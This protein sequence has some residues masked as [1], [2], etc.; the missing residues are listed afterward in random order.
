MESFTLKPKLSLIL[1]VYN[2]MPW[3]NLVLS[4]AIAQRVSVPYEIIVCDDGSSDRFFDEVRRMCAESRPDL[5]YIWQPDEGF[6]LSR[7]RNNAIRCAQGELLVFADGDTWLAP[8]FLQEHLDAHAATAAL[9]C[10]L[11]AT[12]VA[13]DIKGDMLDLRMIGDLFADLRS[14]NQP[15]IE[16]QRAWFNSRRPWMAC[17]G[18]NFSI[19]SQPQY[20]FDEVFEGWG[21]EDRDFAYRMF[22]AGFKPTLLPYANAC[23][24]RRSNDLGWT[25]M[26]SKQV[27]AFLRNKSLLRRKYV[28]REMLPS[29]SLV[30]RC[31]LDELAGRWS[32]GEVRNATVDQ[33]LDQFDRWL[34]NSRRVDRPAIHKF[35]SDEICHCTK[36]ARYGSS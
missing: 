5:K 6:R 36:S 9:V 11:R 25:F 1:S 14:Y 24:I 7:S 3:A 31:H 22:Q 20:C 17:L 33:V 30:L 4:S 32:I 28:S 15:E 12:V 13:P 18:G 26:S 29:L 2:Q 23:Q 10:G 19:P 27:V 21:S 34:E 35:V 8:E 16:K